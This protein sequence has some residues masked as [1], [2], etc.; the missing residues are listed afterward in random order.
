MQKKPPKISAK[1]L[2]DECILFN[3]YDARLDNVFANRAIRQTLLLLQ[4]LGPLHLRLLHRYITFSSLKEERTAIKMLSRTPLL[5]MDQA[6]RGER[7]QIMLSQEAVWKPI[8][9]IELIPQEEY[10]QECLHLNKLLSEALPPDTS[11]ILYGDYASGTATADKSIEI[12]VLGRDLQ[13]VT[14]IVASSIKEV[15]ELFHVTICPTFS[16]SHDYLLYLMGAVK[17]APL[18]LA[19]ALKGIALYGEKPRFSGR[20]LF[21]SIQLLFPYPPAKIRELLNSGTLKREPDGNLAFSDLGIKRYKRQP[22]PTLT[23]RKVIIEGVEAYFL[24]KA[25]QE[26]TIHQMKHP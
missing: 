22:K 6:E 12:F 5:K 13:K 7:K 3:T 24:E 16:F 18:C 2:S 1:A 26:T 8:N 4:E 21:D 11:V 10:V 19:Q 25:T 17:K 15:E 9:V 23:L 20:A 14:S